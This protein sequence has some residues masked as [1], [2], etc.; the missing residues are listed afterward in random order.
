MQNKVAFMQTNDI[1]QPLAKFSDIS[2]SLGL[3][4]RLPIPVNF[5]QAKARGAAAAW[6][7]PIAGMAIA[8][9]VGIAGAFLIHLGINPPISAALAIGL[10]III[11]GAMHE[12]G[13]AD[14]AD[15]LWGGCE[16]ER[17][18]EIMKDSRIGTY[19]VLA[20]VLSLLIRWTALSAIF[21]AGSVFAPLLAVAATSRLPM[22]VLM[23]TLPN[24]RGSG[25][26]ASV[27][28]PSKDTLALGTVIT[29]VAAVIFSGWSFVPLFLFCTVA[30]LLCAQVAKAKIG[31]QTGDILGATQQVVE[32][33]ALVTLA[34]WIA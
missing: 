13:L 14:S 34:S 8:L 16:K 1:E 6:A 32:L 27:G 29:L 24:A 31:G 5:A 19:G 23:T 7:F 10:Q 12:D 15:G 17:R 11:T 20:L 21:G 26:S 3:L 30:T 18:L 28:Q 9:I 4:S 33:T 2:A 25:L 22:L